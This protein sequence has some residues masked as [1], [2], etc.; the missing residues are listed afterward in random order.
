MHVGSG[1]AEK[2]W[3]LPGKL[4]K[5]KS[6]FFTA[7]LEDGFAEGASKHITLPEVDPDIFQWFVVW[8]Y[9]GFDPIEDCEPASLVPLWLLGDR[10]GCPWMQDD[11]MC[12]LIAYHED[13]QIGEVTLKQIFEGSTRGSKLRRFTVDQ[14]L[15][16]VKVWCGTRDVDNWSYSRFVRDNEDFAQEL[17]AATI[18]HGSGRPKDPYYNKSPYLFAP[19]PSTSEKKS[20]S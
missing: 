3:H 13:C 4:L 20:G 12:D 16:D 17:G 10:L 11:V 5:S 7:A 1:D 14:C 2:V 6:T 9:V 8:L 19:L 15:F 18:L